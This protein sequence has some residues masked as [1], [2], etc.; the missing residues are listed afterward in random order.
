[1]A[2]ELIVAKAHQEQLRDSDIRREV[3]SI[4]AVINDVKLDYVDNT[5][6]LV[7]IKGIYQHA[8]RQMITAFL[9]VNRMQETLVEI[10]GEIRL[11]FAAEDALI[12]KATI[13]LD[14]PFLGEI[15]PN[16]ALLLHLSI[17]V[18]GLYEDRSFTFKDLTGRFDNVR[19]TP[20]PTEK[21]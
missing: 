7:V 20:K 19:V 16:Q 15:K 12:A 5:V 10:H 14:E 11:E 8:R 6:N 21:L 13:D 1:M 9:L 2:I 4:A 3:D 18:K 17:P